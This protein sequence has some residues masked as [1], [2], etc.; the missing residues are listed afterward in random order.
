MSKKYAR[1]NRGQMPV[2]PPADLNTLASKVENDQVRLQTVTCNLCNGI[3]H[4]VVPRVKPKMKEPSS[5]ENIAAYETAVAAEKAAV[6]ETTRRYGPLAAYF[7]PS[8]RRHRTP[9]ETTTTG[10]V[11]AGKPEAPKNRC[12]YCRNE[13]VRVELENPPAPFYHPAIAEPGAPAVCIQ[14]RKYVAQQQ[15]VVG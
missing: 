8:C 10:N 9:A 7:C 13:V 4:P 6:E 14:E 3:A 5:P 12:A 11:I 15:V 2:A 1:D